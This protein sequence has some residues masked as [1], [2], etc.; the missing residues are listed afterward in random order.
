MGIWVASAALLSILSFARPAAAHSFPD[1]RLTLR[2]STFE[3]G[4]GLGL[5]HL[6]VADY[7]GLGIN[8]ELGYG[9]TSAAGVPLPHR[10]APG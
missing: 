1:Q 8:L 10:P 6:D 5:G 2:G 3:M 4:L 9:I 7:T